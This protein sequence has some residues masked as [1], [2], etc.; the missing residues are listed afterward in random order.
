LRPGEWSLV[1]LAWNLKRTFA[2]CPSARGDIRLIPDINVRIA[3]QLSHRRGLRAGAA[4]MIVDAV[5][6]GTCPA[7]P[8]QLVIS[9]PMIEAYA[10]MLRTAAGL[11]AN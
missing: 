9:L 2:L 10:N 4:T 6:D 11:L 5:K 1:I 7:R 8:V 3:D